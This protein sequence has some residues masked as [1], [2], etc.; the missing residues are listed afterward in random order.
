MIAG[1]DCG[2]AQFVHR[3]AAEMAINQMQGYPIGNSCVLLS[4]GR[5]QNNLGVGTPYCPA[6]RSP[7]L[8]W[9][10]V[11]AAVTTTT[12][13][14]ITTSKN[15]AFLL[16]EA[17][18]VLEPEVEGYSYCWGL[19]SMGFPAERTSQTYAFVG[20]G[21]SS[22]TV[23]ELPLG[24][25]YDDDPFTGF[26]VPAVYN[27]YEGLAFVKLAEI[28]LRQHHF[29]TIAI[30]EKESKRLHTKADPTLAMQETVHLRSFF[31]KR[32]KK[33]KQGR[34]WREER[35]TSGC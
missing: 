1:N 7:S 14:T 9:E 16:Q 15:F 28:A 3:H 34:W 13:M 31:K 10:L 25:T 30:A 18:K 19:G 17:P 26:T 20:L 12:T 24:M 35:R 6:P 5:S 32:N 33:G 11:M 8:S 23:S 29:L 21:S 22:G 2:F 4:G 27:P